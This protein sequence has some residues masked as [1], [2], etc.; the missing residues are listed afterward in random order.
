MVHAA[1]CNS[2][3]LTRCIADDKRRS[4]VALSL[5]YNL[6]S[7]CRISSECNLS[8]IYITI[9]HGNLCKG[10]LSN[11]F[12]CC[13]E[14]AHLTDVGSLRSLSACVGVHLGIKYHN[15]DIFT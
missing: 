11:L 3:K 7:L 6:H 4:V 5:T 10:F 8:H 13:G 1:L 14:L 2:V 12:T 15:I 9:T